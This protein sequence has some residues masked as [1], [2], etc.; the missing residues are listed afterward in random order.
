MIAY[1]ELRNRLDGEKIVALET[2]L[3]GLGFPLLHTAP[4][5]PKALHNLVKLLIT[6]I[7]KMLFVL[8]ILP[9]LI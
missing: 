9:Y 3:G 2:D 5:S 4:N 1:G 7:M 8:R 6:E